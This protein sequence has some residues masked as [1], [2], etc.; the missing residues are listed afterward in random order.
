MAACPRCGA[1]SSTSELFCSRCGRR[2]SPTRAERRKLVTVVFTDLVGSTELEEGLDTE[3][4][5]DVVLQYYALMRAAVEEHGGRVEKFLGDAVLAVFGVPAAHEDDAARALRAALAMRARLDELNERLK[6]EYGVRLAVHTG[7]HSGVVLSG[8]DVNDDGFVLGST[9]NVA[10]RL[11]EAAGN[12]EILLSETTYQL[13]KQ[14]ARVEEL[15]PMAA[16]GVAGELRCYRLL[17]LVEGDGTA[18]RHA[19]GLVGREKELAAM[20]HALEEVAGS[21]SARLLLLVGEPGIGKSRLAD[22]LCGS[23]GATVLSGPCLS[24]GEAITYWPLA[25]ILRQAVGVAKGD[26]VEHARRRLDE[27]F[28]QSPQSS[29]AVTVLAP[30]LGAGHGSVTSEDIIW[31]TRKLLE[32]VSKAGPVILRLDDLQWAEEQWLEVLDAL[33]EDS[34]P[35]LLLGLARPEMRTRRPA[36]ETLMLVGLS[37]GESRRLV[38]QLAELTSEQQDLIA[39]RAGGNPLFIE[40]LVSAA[41]ESS[42]GLLPLTLDALLHARLDRLEA[43]QR[44]VLEAGA[45]E[46]QEFHKSIV[47]QL[48]AELAPGEIDEAL[49]RLVESELIFRNGSSLNGEDATYRFRSLVIRDAAYAAIPK[50]VRATQHERLGRFLCN[51]YARSAGEWDELAGYHLEQSVLNRAELGKLDS[52]ANGV[53]VEAADRLVAAARRAFSRGDTRAATTLYDRSLR[54]LHGAA[55]RRLELVPEVAEVL[56]LAGDQAGAEAML[57]EGVADALAAGDR[58]L[59]MACRIAQQHLAVKT[60]AGWHGDEAL[61]AACEGLE[62][63]AEASDYANMARAATLMGEVHWLSFRGAEMESAYAQALE[64]CEMAGDPPWR[65]WIL[66]ML[67]IVYYHGPMPVPEAI[68]RCEEILA[69]G[70][71]HGVVEVGARTK[72]AGLLAMRGEI[73]EALALCK[74]SR[75]IAEEIG[76][77][78]AIAGMTNYVGPI[79]LLGDDLEGA[80]SS[81]REGCA[82]LEANGYRP[83]LSTSSALLA[84]TLERKG[85]VEE[86][87]WWAHKSR[88]LASPDDVAT[89]I[90]LRGVT[91]RLLAR[92]GHFDEARRE[93]YAGLERAASTDFLNW[94]GE[95]LLDCAHVLSLAGDGDAADTARLAQRLFEKKGNLVLA[96]EA[97]RMVPSTGNS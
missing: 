58:R 45:V 7:I 1:E 65:G 21:G 89:E 94:H 87:Q 28:A 84:R 3:T 13:V 61:K 69:L 60:D 63:F 36:W 46:G 41:L 76:L 64:Y 96:A 93:A 78:V 29:R 39:R 19:A 11:E 86:A 56:M 44:N 91:A 2:L 50:R 15:G 92:S 16:K 38:S 80:E 57:A 81:L 10:A 48:E 47:E 90:L 72:I 34:L 85:E 82:F 74:E 17:G 73:D 5:R 23:S 88:A 14:L 9:A 25:E 40:E 67:P 37:N 26:S 83:T 33:A 6:P 20:A 51:S 24:Y 32:V 31:A 54:L 43:A 95:S 35:V 75:A 30:L 27:L 59:V 66:R 97:A 77:D 55:M 71:G 70:K 12:S 53:A 49:A 18:R 22:E 62:T 52:H 4:V 42:N 79:H 68:T 8:A